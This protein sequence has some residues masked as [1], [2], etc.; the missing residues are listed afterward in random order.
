MGESKKDEHNRCYLEACD[1]LKPHMV[2]QG[3]E[4]APMNEENVRKGIAL[5]ERVVELSDNQNWAALW[6]KG[7]AHQSLAEHQEA[8]ESFLGAYRI[9]NTHPDVL[10]ELSLEA[11]QIQK[12]ADAL[13]YAKAAAE[14]DLNDPGLIANVA[15]ALIF[16]GRYDEALENAEKACKLDPKDE[17]SKKLLA[18][19]KH[20]QANHLPTPRT[21]E[22]LEA[23]FGSCI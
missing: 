10:R 11:H 21:I 17:V 22:E 6:I 12:H 18:V 7:K 19:I 5:L 23:V 3:E 2:L 9:H 16:N 20:V 8:Y 4:L 14:F 13:Y 1:L 15:F